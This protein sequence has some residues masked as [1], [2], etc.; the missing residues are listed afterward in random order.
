MELAGD[1]HICPGVDVC[2][3]GG[4]YV[5]VLVTTA[6]GSVT[7]NCNVSRPTSLP[8]FPSAYCTQYTIQPTASNC[9]TSTTNIPPSSVLTTTT[10]SAPPPAPTVGIIV[11][12]PISETSGCKT[13]DV[14]ANSVNATADYMGEQLSTSIFTSSTGNFT[15]TYRD[16]GASGRGVTYMMSI[17]W[18][19]GCKTYASQRPDRPI[20]PT[21]EFDWKGLLED[22]YYYCKLLCTVAREL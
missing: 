9:P 12:N 2:N 6:G 14:H 5:P 13:S 22:N 18:I 1:Q 19:P 8:T 10:T 16:G 11:C 21:V 20:D 4:T 3:C 17:G 15:R 7:G